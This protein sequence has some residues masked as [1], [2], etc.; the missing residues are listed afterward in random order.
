MRVCN[1]HRLMIRSPRDESGSATIWALAFMGV[2]AALAWIGLWAASAVA[3]QH[4]LDG[5]ADL[6]SLA[7]AAVLQ[8]GGDACAVARETAKDNAATVVACSVVHSDVLVTV[9]ESVQLPFGLPGSFQS[10]ARAGPVDVS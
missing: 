10:A 8:S 7:G 3:L 6:A 4:H 2:S 1:V 5:S 9:K